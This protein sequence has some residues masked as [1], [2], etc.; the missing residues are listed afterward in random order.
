MPPLRLAIATCSTH[1]H[2][3][4]SDRPV[5][6]ALARLN[7]PL[8]SLGDAEYHRAYSSSWSTEAQSCAE[9]SS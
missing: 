2:A 8:R 4:P 5:L 6:S 9:S 1:H 7:V 3:E